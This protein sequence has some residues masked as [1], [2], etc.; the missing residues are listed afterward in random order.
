MGHIE[1]S[2]NTTFIVLIPKKGGAN[3]LKD[4]QPISLV[5]NLYK[6]L[7]KVLANILKTV[8][9]KVISNSQH[10][11]LKERQILDVAFISNNALDS[12]LTGSESEVICKMDIENA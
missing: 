12:R 9:G 2:L 7:A 4:F 1:R 8:G 10:I 11:F 3:N 6:L 5:V